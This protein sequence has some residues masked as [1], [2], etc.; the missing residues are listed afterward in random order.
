[1]SAIYWTD[2]YTKKD[3][4]EFD[5]YATCV[6]DGR[7]WRVSKSGQTYCA[8]KIEKLKESKDERL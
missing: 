1:M 2:Q 7:A 8:G 5:S 3:P 6:I 4:K